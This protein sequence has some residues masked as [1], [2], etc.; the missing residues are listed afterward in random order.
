MAQTPVVRLRR[1]LGDTLRAGHPW[2]YRDAL[3]TFAA[4]PGTI[5]TLVDQKGAF[6][7]RGY[8]NEGAIALRV[9]T[10]RDVAIDAFFL[11]RRIASALSLRQ[12][13][14]PPETDAYRLLHGEGDLLPGITLDRYG[15]YAVMR[16]DGEA[17]AAFAE[18]LVPRLEAPL[19]ELGITCLLQ[20]LA[21]REA[22]RPEPLWGKPPTGPIIVQEHGMRLPADLLEGQKTGL[23]L[24]HRESRYR[25]RTLSR[26][27]KV[28]NLYAYTGG[29]SIAA[30]LGGAQRVASV[31]VSAGALSLAEQGFSENG[32]DD[33]PH[34]TVIDDVP[35]W[36]SEGDKG[37]PWDLIIADPPSFAPSE[38]AL[39]KA[40]E[41]YRRLHQA[42]L[43]RLVPGGLY[44]A[45]SC[46][47]H[48]GQSLFEQ[49]LAQGA[50]HAGRVLQVLERWG[51]PA[52][53][54]RLAAFPE[55]DYLT[56]ALAR[57]ASV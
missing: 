13:I 16:V 50:L 39:D 4:P 18:R 52:D 45:A 46:S 48:V 34:Q 29:F 19:R 21:R 10:T 41:A 2:V 40:L 28:L 17:A 25:V 33:I 35:R 30:A 8:A 1:K 57:V 51:A 42:V 12:R 43:K 47:S 7:A 5:I 36:L 9:L 31:D 37:P 55:G 24:D 27:L 56:V 44:L 11:D 54:P 15:A 23:F 38:K 53:H 6:V 26:G 14:A 22:A 3:E 49:T 20:R 32:L